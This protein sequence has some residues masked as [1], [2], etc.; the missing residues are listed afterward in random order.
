MGVRN[1]D[2][3]YFNSNCQKLRKAA[4]YNQITTVSS[5][6]EQQMK[7]NQSTRWINQFDKFGWSALHYASFQGN[8]TICQALV[9]AGADVNLRTERAGET[10]LFLAAAVDESKIVDY[11]INEAQVDPNISDITGKI[12]LEV[13]SGKSKHIISEER[14]KHGRIIRLIPTVRKLLAS[15][16]TQILLQLVLCIFLELFQDKLIVSIKLERIYI[17]I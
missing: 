2:D 16:F 12:P 4:F 3:R 7:E 17:I 8:L 6:I 5:L 14:L 10:P 1:K 11:L 9:K 15:K 13:A